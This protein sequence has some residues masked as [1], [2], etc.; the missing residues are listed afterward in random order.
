MLHCCEG[1]TRT[2]DGRIRREA[3]HVC[4]DILLQV[5]SQDGILASYSHLAKITSEGHICTGKILQ[6][7]K[8]E[9]CL[10]LFKNDPWS[11][12]YRLLIYGPH[13]HVNTSVSRRLFSVV[14]CF[15]DDCIF[16]LLV[17]ITY[18]IG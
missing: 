7:V 1:Q 18:K 16:S 8:T 10:S 15:V 12:L 13:T 4:E 14:N 6:A 11:I 9:G 3:G 17:I 5:V 2:F